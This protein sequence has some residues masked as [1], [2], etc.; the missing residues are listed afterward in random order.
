MSSGNDDKAP[1]GYYEWIK[2]RGNAQWENSKPWLE[3]MYLKYFSNDNKAS[4][5]TRGLLPSTY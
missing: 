4:Y 5:A 1:E 2:N 3:D